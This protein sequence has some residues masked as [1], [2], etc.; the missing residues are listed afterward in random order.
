MR[1]VPP[2]IFIG[3]AVFLLGLQLA[4]FAGYQAHN[5]A[6]E[7]RTLDREY[8]DYQVLT[9]IGLMIAS[10]GTGIVAYGLGKIPKSAIVIGAAVFLFG[11][12]LAF[13]AGY[14]A[15]NIANEGRTLDREYYD[16]Q[17]LTVIGLMIASTGTG[18]VAY[19][20]VFE[21]HENDA[22]KI[23]KSAIVMGTAVFAF[24]FGTACWASLAIQHMMMFSQYEAERETLG[25]WAFIGFLVGALGMLITICGLASDTRTHARK[26]PRN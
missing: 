10:T 4:F 13:L 3:V 26:R 9:V 1:A 14:Q 2:V 12:G 25:S 11:F 15:H 5:I 19:V 21:N 24:G 7:S 6:N 8:Y 20:L 16:Y 18:I 23:P 22:R 17:V